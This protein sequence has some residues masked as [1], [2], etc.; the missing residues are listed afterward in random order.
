MERAKRNAVVA[1]ALVVLAVA[2]ARVEAQ[3]NSD[4]KTLV[5][6]KRGKKYCDKGWECKGWSIYCCNLTITDYFQTYQFENLFSKRNTP[7]AHA[8]G[9]WDYH[10][11]IAAAAL[12][13]PQGFGT[14]GNK[15]MQ[16]MEIAAFLGHVGSKTSCEF[17]TFHIFVNFVCG[18]CV[19]GLECEN[20]CLGWACGFE[21]VRSVCAVVLELRLWMVL[22]CFC[23]VWFYCCAV[24]PDLSGTESVQ[25]NFHAFSPF[26]HL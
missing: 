1:I 22:I 13:E 5:K 21:I 25:S 6:Y 2:A 19:S 9:F 14:T 4:V 24:K 10:S 20:F 15:T 8:V 7:V 11:F 3:E 26:S 18:L 16:M 17:S 12:F 23:V